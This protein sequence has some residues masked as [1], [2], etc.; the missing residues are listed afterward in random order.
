M[1][2]TTVP[3]AFRYRPG[4]E[5]AIHD[6]VEKLES[7][8]STVLLDAP[9]G[10]GKSLI[11]ITV[12]KILWEKHH[13]RTWLT[14]PLVSLVEQYRVDNLTAPH[15]ATIMGRRNYECDI[16]DFAAPL[17]TIHADEAY[18]VTGGPCY[19]CKG[20]G[21]TD[22][23]GCHGARK[24][25]LSA[26]QWKAGCPSRQNLRC[27][28]YN[29]RARVISHDLSVATL[30]YLSLASLGDEAK[31]F[32]PRDLLIVD[33]ADDLAEMGVG[34]LAFQLGEDTSDGRVWRDHWQL[35]LL[36]T[37]TALRDDDP[38][39]LRNAMRETQ[40][41]LSFIGGDLTRRLEEETDGAAR[42]KLTRRIERTKSLAV[43]CGWVAEDE[44]PWIASIEDTRKGFYVSV[45]P[46]YGGSFLK[47]RLW[48]LAPQRILAS[49]TFGAIPGYLK[50]VHLDTAGV[51]G[52][53]SCFPPVNAPIF[54]RRLG[55]LNWESKT[56]LT[57]VFIAA[58]DEILDR[59]AGR[60]ILFVP[61]YKLSETIAFGIDRRHMS[62]LTQHGP[63]D[64]N[65]TLDQWLHNGREDSVLIGVDMIR[66]LD[67]QGKLAAWSVIVK[68]PWPSLGDKRVVV[69]KAMADGDAWY[70]AQTQRALWQATGRIVRSEVDTGRT[71]VL[72]SSA[73][74]L[75][76][77]QGSPNWGLKR[78]REGAKIASA[79]RVRPW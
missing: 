20:D 37:M 49:G 33:E 31:G 7:G 68:A 61:S 24:G 9:V 18:C 72:D 62:R 58:I 69:R 67:L 78:I 27:A 60:G 75:M 44:E 73:C 29:A 52:M 32:G 14:S 36:P 41:R 40:E 1:Q 71:Y 48:R 55:Y 65:L 79:Q 30:S 26:G 17:Q 56:E 45:T 43:K 66:G 47:T 21:P 74:D 6:L 57:P 59:E 46:V 38:G 77:S 51:V 76:M 70:K 64:R 16:G 28:Y 63:Q 42:R 12:A 5:R 13:W 34:M 25:F 39:L 54:L 4:Q 3:P 50:E 15:I 35:N 19:V 22:C 10:S 8:T 53:D 23:P 2:A 11:L